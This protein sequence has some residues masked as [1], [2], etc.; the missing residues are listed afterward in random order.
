MLTFTLDV[1]RR[2]R[3]RR[4]NAQLPKFCTNSRMRL[5]LPGGS[6]GLTEFKSSYGDL[7]DKSLKSQGTKDSSAPLH[8]PTTSFIHD[9]EVDIENTTATAILPFLY[10]GNE[11]DAADLQRLKDLNITYVL[12]VTSHIPYQHEHQ[13]I[14]YKR[15]PASD[16]CQQNL[17][18]YFQEAFDF[19][20]EARNSGANVLVHCHAG[21]SRSATITIAYLLKHTRMVMVDAYK[22]VK[23]K[24]SIISPNFNFMG[25]LLE[26]EQALN[27]GK[28]Q[29]VLEPRLVIETS[30]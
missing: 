11:R 13:G 8:S 4:S 24:R 16:S 20:E 9:Q 23:N 3:K 17:T 18:Q 27:S 15:L 1:P 2:M 26:F 28:A 12:N 21:V 22:Y 29:R 7:C 10:L 5:E 19:I 30:V 6:G 25:Q 14:K